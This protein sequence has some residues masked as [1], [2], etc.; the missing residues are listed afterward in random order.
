MPDGKSQIHG[1]ALPSGS[2]FL[3]EVPE[4]WNGIVLFFS[5][6]VPIKA[7]EP[8]WR[9]GDPPIAQLVGHGYAVAGSA[10][11][12]FWPLER[13]FADH[14]DLFEL[15][16]QVL[17]APRHV[18]ACGVSIG[19]IMTAGLVQLFPHHLS[20]ALPM[21]GNLAGAVANHN[22]ELDVAFAIK[23]LLAPNSPLELTH[24]IDGHA[25]LDLALDI[26]REA[27]GSAH[28][29]ARLGLAA[30]LGDIP[31]WYDPTSAEP[32]PDDYAGRLRNQISWFEEPGF[33]VYFLA[34]RQVEMQAGGNPSWNTGVDYRKLLSR[35]INHDEVKA[36]YDEAQVDLDDDLDRLAGQDR[37]EADPKAVAYLES[38][39]VFTGDLGGVPVL[40]MHSDGDGL[41]PPGHERAYAEVVE[42]AGNE[43]LLRQLYVHRGGHCTFTGAEILT[44]LDL[45]VERIETG[46][47][48]DHDP[49]T[50]KARAHGQGPTNNVLASGVTTQAQFFDFEPPP[51][52]R[53]H[54]IRDVSAS[55]TG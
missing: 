49:V 37:I 17:P 52:S 5:H 23:T 54:D 53:Q 22:R 51:F 50:L 4:A 41:V 12:I 39:I 19:G 28:G 10:N 6:P 26:L 34:R 45:L 30:A 16:G 21:C 48:S 13:V 38:H 43:S 2:Q 27:E 35:S 3:I 55:V 36:L 20:G 40:T 7:G 8:P 24:I 18:I 31:G 32:A 11:T 47:W 42:H 1:G 46:S 9:P 14:G 25:N 15:V 29:R 44:A 33:L